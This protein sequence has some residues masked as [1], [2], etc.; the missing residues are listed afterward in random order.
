MCDASTG[1]CAWAPKDTGC[2]DG[3]PCTED[4][5]DPAG[6]CQHLPEDG[7]CDDG[8]P[9]TVDSC[10]ASAGCAHAP[11]PGACDDGDACT[12]GDLCADGICAAGAAKT[13]QDG[14]PCT[15]DVCDP[16][17]GACLFPANDAA[18][19]DGDP[20]TETACVDGACAVL[21]EVC[22]DLYCAPCKEDG[23]C[24]APGNLCMPEPGGGGACGVD[25]AG[26]P[27]IC[28]EGA[29]CEPAGGGLQ[30]RPVSGSCKPVVTP[31]DSAED[32]VVVLDTVGAPENGAPET[33][34]QGE[35]GGAEDGL[36]AGE[37]AT[38]DADGAGSGGCGVG[39][40]STSMLGLLLLL[41]AGLGL[42]RARPLRRLRP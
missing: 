17:T 19:T 13:C 9:C 28:P 42:S 12:V 36:G 14:N 21:D 34:G 15:D 16:A 32:V 30:C 3:N 37:P 25:C 40:G 8:N 33:V 4:L 26:A 35:A 1:D 38:Y 2:D 20:C 5:C 18:C 24:G 27:E 31:P 22:Q 41:I 29:T 7:A 11:G 39:A 10:D 6:G 23:D